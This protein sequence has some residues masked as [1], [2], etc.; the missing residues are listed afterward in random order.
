MNRLEILLEALEKSDNISYN[1]KD[2]SAV[3]EAKRTFERRVE[4]LFILNYFLRLR[5]FIKKIVQ[6]N[7]LN[8]QNIESL[9]WEGLNVAD[10]GLI[11]C[12]CT[13]IYKEDIEELIKEYISRAVND[14]ENQ[15]LKLW[16]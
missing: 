3:V 16:G 1:K 5:P 8:L 12:Q 14:I 7:Y 4:Q 2:S 15:T 9:I 6:T 11:D 10:D 13:W